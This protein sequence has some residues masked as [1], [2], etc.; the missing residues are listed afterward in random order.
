M[1]RARSRRNVARKLRL[2][3]WFAF[4]DFDQAQTWCEM[5]ERVG[6]VARSEPALVSE[7][8]RDVGTEFACERVAQCEAYALDTVDGG[9]EL[10][11][12]NRT[13][14]QVD[15]R[16][17]VA[18]RGGGQPLRTGAAAQVERRAAGRARRRTCAR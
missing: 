8:R 9:V 16:N 13:R 5:H 10:R 3:W 12:T 18:V 4:G 1:Q 11:E 7:P 2:P 6:N 17:L 14:V 15:A